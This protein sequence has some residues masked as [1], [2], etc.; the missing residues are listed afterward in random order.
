M[1]KNYWIN[2]FFFKY[3]YIIKYILAG[4]ERFRNVTTSY[5]RGTQGCLVVYDVTNI[6]SFEMV[7]FLFYILKKF[8][9]ILE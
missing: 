1:N 6:G 2:K 3:I 7:C 8:I 5:Y 9:S 4:Q